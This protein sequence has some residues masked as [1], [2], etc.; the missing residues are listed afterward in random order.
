MRVTSSRSS[1]AVD[2][3]KARVFMNDSVHARLSSQ[4]ASPTPSRLVPGKDSFQ[5]LQLAAESLPHG[6]L[7]VNP[8]GA[9]VLVN[10]QIE[11]QFGYCRTELIGQSVDRLLPE[12][13]LGEY[14]LHSQSF[15][16][17]PE[18]RTMGVDQTLFGRRRDG[19]EFPVEITLNS[20][21]IGQAVFVAAS[22]VDLTARREL[23]QAASLA[24]DQKVEFEQLIAELSVKFINLPPDQVIE[25]TRDAIR[26]VAEMLAVDCCT[27]SRI[28]DGEF[29]A[30]PIAWWGRPGV[31]S[32]PLVVVK[33]RFPWVRETILAGNELCFATLDEVPSPVDRREFESCGIRA[34]V[35]VPISVCG[36]VVGAVGFSMMRHERSWTMDTLH[37]IRVL[38]AVFGNILARCENDETLRQSIL[39]LEHLRDRVRVEN[40]YLRREIQERVDTGVI[41]GQS[42]AIRN[43]LEQA[44]QVA[45]TDS[46]VLLLGETGTG[47]E[48]IATHIH[49]LSARR[50]RIM[51]RVNCSA[52]PSTLMESEL[53]GREKGA[54]TGALAR[55]IGRFELADHS[56]IFLDEI[57]EL[58]ADVQVKL[59]RVL[60]ERQI[61]RLGSPKG[62]HVDVRIIAATHRN[63]EKRIAE[64]AFREDLF[65]RLNVF[66][67]QV[68]PLRDRVEDI[69]L[70]VWRFVDEFSKAFGKRI[71]TIS[72]EDM[73]VLQRYSW[74]GNIRELRNVVERAMI[75]ST[76]TQLA[77]PLP[78]LSRPAEKRSLKLNDV[79]KEHILSVLDGV[80]WRIRGSAGAAALLGL[81]PTTLEARMAKLGLTRPK[82]ASAPRVSL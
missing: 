69:P 59:L 26:R 38:A 77:L 18:A 76:G 6:M 3:V 52:I 17:V 25:A 12:A 35:K 15:D 73:A 20:M 23:E 30:G 55:Q 46:T 48:L 68:P 45:A 61:E 63:L 14:A 81:K 82:P 75:V 5:V 57:G 27:F 65:Y 50:G 4:D 31:S 24:I 13:L 2:S 53:F 62:V 10:Q 41:I 47:K 74:P 44:R 42:Q 11:R 34:A 79:E 80:G 60:E 58:P 39:Q 70:L 8:N 56:T 19:S 54:F 43:V 36:Q 37:T 16:T 72:R 1:S 21:Q 33:E 28:P 64:G 51:V 7:V 29:S 67:I 40:L 9:I 32:S 71:E 66:P 22:V 49:E 78:S